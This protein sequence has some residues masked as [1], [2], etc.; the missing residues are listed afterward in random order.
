MPRAIRLAHMPSAP[1][2]IRAPFATLAPQQSLQASALVSFS[3]FT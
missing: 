2:A 3:R 1:R